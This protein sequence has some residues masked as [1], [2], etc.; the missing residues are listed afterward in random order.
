MKCEPGLDQNR[1][2]QSKSE[3]KRQK[4]RPKQTTPQN[5][6]HIHRLTSF[7][8]SQGLPIPGIPELQLPY[9]L[10]NLSSFSLLP[11]FV[12]NTKRRWYIPVLLHQVCTYHQILRCWITCT[13]SSDQSGYILYMAQQRS[14]AP[15]GAVRCGA[16]PFA[17]VLC[18][19]AVCFLS[20]I[21]QY[22]V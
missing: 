16:V 18:R 4:S 19:Y 20:N 14:V 5:Q 21:E 10:R 6:V 9:Y 13:P 17:A 8:L 1:K 11:S 22:R 12:R 15:C 7:C 2:S 3:S